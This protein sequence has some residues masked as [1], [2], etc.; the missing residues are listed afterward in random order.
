MAIENSIPV[1]PELGELTDVA[2]GIPSDTTK[3]V[4]YVKG[5]ATN[6]QARLS[7]YIPLIRSIYY[8]GTYI[9]V[10][11][12][13][14]PATVY[15]IDPVTMLTIGVWTGAGGQNI[16]RAVT[17]TLGG[18]FVYAAL[19][20]TP[21][22][23]VKI[24]ISNPAV[25]VTSIIWTGAAGQN[26]ATSIVMG[27]GGWG[28]RIF[29]GLHLTPAQVVHI[30]EVA[31]VLVTFGTWTGAA[32]QN[33]ADSLT[34]D[35]FAAAQRQLIVGLNITPAQVVRVNVNTMATFLTW[36]GA[37]GQNLCQ[38][39][40]FDG[41][42]YYAGLGTSPAQVVKITSATMTTDTT[43][44][45]DA[46]M[47]ECWS[48]CF[49]SLGNLYVGLNSTPGM[50]VKLLTNDMSQIAVWTDDD[51]TDEITAITVSNGKTVFLCRYI[52]RVIRTEIPDGVPANI[53][54]IV[55]SLSI[56]TDK[57][58]TVWMY[59]T[60]QD[61]SAIDPLK[62]IVLNPAVTAFSSPWTIGVH[63]GR[64][65]PV[66]T[67]DVNQTA[68]LTGIQRWPNYANLLAPFGIT[69][70]TSGMVME[71]EMQIGDGLNSLDNTLCVFGLVY[72]QAST[73]AS[74]YINAFA[75]VGATNVLQ[76]VTDFAG[77]ETT[78][79]GFGEDKSIWNKYKIMVLSGHVM[80][81]LNETLISDHTTN[82]QAA[83]LY[84]KFY[85]DSNAINISDIGI[86]M[87]RIGFLTS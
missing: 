78:N 5:L 67:L 84:P 27:T 47:T 49:D 6:V 80:F 87:F 15:I 72:T 29:V 60:W 20:T 83:D 30:Q 33:N 81:Y 61:E 75:L 22:Q 18:T 34:F 65:S 7:A 23:V 69:T 63:G 77:A 68:G 19:Y 14:S 74:D 21:A 41:Y 76:T 51:N 32:G 71:W 56:I 58:N 25:P 55:S 86:G 38:A 73:R 48:L 79:T 59:E 39:L 85:V 70:L 36:T 31:G 52:G 53:A 11:T 45:G 43:W 1:I 13:S 50:V 66:T 40:A 10:G 28:G 24:D 3:I 46:L 9:I 54:A 12:G 2:S 17:G 8:T 4:S 35:H 57:L 26:E 37:G 62:W 44:T 82:V 42:D 16:C 64:L